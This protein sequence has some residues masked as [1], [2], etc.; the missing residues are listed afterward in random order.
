MKE[1]A[2]L[3]KRNRPRLQAPRNRRVLDRYDERTI[4]ETAPPGEAERTAL[5]ADE[6]CPAGRRW[7]MRWSKPRIIE[8]AVGLEINSYACAGM[9]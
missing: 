1:I 4:C 7:M 5:D 3:G 9:P 6:V 8:V 2:A